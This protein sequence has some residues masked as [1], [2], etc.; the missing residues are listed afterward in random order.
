MKN[1]AMVTGMEVMNGLSNMDF[2]LPR[3]TLPQPL[4]S[5]Q[6]ASSRDQYG[7]THQGD[8]P[9]SYLIAD[10]DIGPLP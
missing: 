9:A 10:D 1:V 8:R 6:S 3:P 2:H 4:L 5:I 7:A